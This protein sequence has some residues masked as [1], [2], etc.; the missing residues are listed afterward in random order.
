[1]LALVRLRLAPA[2][3]TFAIVAV[4][5]QVRAERAG[6]LSAG[7]LHTWVGG[8]SPTFGNGAELTWMHYPA[9]E[10]SDQPFAFGPFAQLSSY[11]W[12]HA[13]FALGGQ[14]TFHRFVGLELGW[15][16]R[17]AHGDRAANNGAQVAP[18]LTIGLV[19]LGAQWT[20]TP[21]EPTELSVTLAFKLP[22][23][24]LYG[25]YPVLWPGR[26]IR[27]GGNWGA[28]GRPLRTAQGIVL[29]DVRVGRRRG[30]ARSELLASLWLADARM[31]HAS[32][33]AFSRL[34]L[35]LLTHGA[36]ASLVRRTHRA[37]AQEIVHAADCFAMASRY[38]GRELSA[39]PMDLPPLRVRELAA[40][41]GESF[42]DGCIGEGVAAAVARAGARA[43][44]DP[45][46]RRVLNRIAR[47]EAEHAELAWDVLAFALARGG[48]EVARALVGLRVDPVVEPLSPDLAVH[49][50]IAGARARAL[51]QR[52]TRNAFARLTKHLSAASATARARSETLRR[53]A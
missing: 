52:V 40:I 22:V 50:R 23:A 21:R 15:A 6:V 28:G 26:D 4:P 36:P 53:G 18:F 46:V 25:E 5:A 32:V 51:R 37:A 29:P 19:A 24:F 14:L 31:E 34:G 20:L 43:T 9:R 2:A 45:E 16:H 44:T 49:G 39:G 12:T 8:P 48:D 13:R 11:G 10:S 42:L 7:Y 30:R 47:Q 38:A 41:A 27:F 1:M 17:G 33:A 3:I 35:E